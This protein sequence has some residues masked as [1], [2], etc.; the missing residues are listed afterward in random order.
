MHCFLIDEG[1]L[2]NLTQS[3]E[4]LSV[5]PENENKEGMRML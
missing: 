5:L 3:A 2:L 4:H 1:V